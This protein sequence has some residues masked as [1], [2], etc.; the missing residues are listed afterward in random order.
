M[1]IKNVELSW[2]YEDI[3]EKTTLAHIN[4][5]SWYNGEEPLRKRA[6]TF[7]VK[8]ELD[9]EGR[10][11]KKTIYEY[12]NPDGSYDQ[13]SVA[14]HFYGN[15]GSHA[16]YHETFYRA[17]L[18]GDKVR[19]DKFSASDMIESYGALPDTKFGT[20]GTMM[21]SKRDAH[22]ENYVTY[23]ADV[24]IGTESSRNVNMSIIDDDRPH[25]VYRSYASKTGLPLMANTDIPSYQSHMIRDVWVAKKEDAD[26][27][28]K[29]KKVECEFSLEEAPDARE[30]NYLPAEFQSVDVHVDY[31][32]REISINITTSN[33]FVNGTEFGKNLSKFFDDPDFIL[34]KALKAGAKCEKFK[35]FCTAETYHKVAEKAPNVVVTVE[36]LVDD[37]NQPSRSI[38]LS[39]E[40]YDDKNMKVFSYDVAYSIFGDIK[41]SQYEYSNG[42][43]TNA[44]IEFI[45]K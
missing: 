30:F 3:D 13:I 25:N 35:D 29:Y 41:V 38:G 39:I 37:A 12:Q 45:E 2:T 44:M 21:V 43:A 1:K 11:S 5:K 18:P 23:G 24:A 16:I 32:R 7:K 27:E 4:K 8:K 19:Y 14:N 17:A 15:D 31:D 22:R 34:N 33:V 40:G 42:R 9:W 6:R 20:D 36:E 26:R 28:D 10:I